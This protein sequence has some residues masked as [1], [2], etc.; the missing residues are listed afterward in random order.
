VIDTIV[1]HPDTLYHLRIRVET[2]GERFVHR[3]RDGVDGNDAE[4]PVPS[5]SCPGTEETIVTT[6]NHPSYVL[7]RPQPGFFAADELVPGDVF[8]LADGG[9]AK[10]RLWAPDL[11][12]GSKGF[13]DMTNGLGSDG[14]GYS[15]PF[16]RGEA[17][18]GLEARLTTIR[19]KYRSLVPSNPNRT[20]M[21][22]ELFDAMNQGAH[23]KMGLH[24]MF[25]S[26]AKSVILAK[27]PGIL[28][29]NW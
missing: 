6:G 3:A 25:K 24:L 12:P 4:P 9:T 17:P 5:G 8:S 7:S 29:G 26:I 18:E 20:A 19:A 16:H 15:A 14:D 27:N 13:A 11:S 10:R 1:T 23:G 28:P 22:G 21:L 2:R